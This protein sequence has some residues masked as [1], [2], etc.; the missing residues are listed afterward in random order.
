M[1]PYPTQAELKQILHY[2]PNTGVFTWRVKTTQ[3]TKVGAVAGC[4]D[5]HNNCS[6]IRIDNKAFLAHRLAWIYIYGDTDKGIR[7]ING[8][9]YDN[10]IDNLALRFKETTAKSKGR[11]MSAIDKLIDKIVAR[12]QGNDNVNVTPLFLIKNHNVTRATAGVIC[13]KLQELKP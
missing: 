9:G 4:F 12:Y 1:K 7:H 2:D 8:I 10:R 6:V 3:T 13:S 5:A 11:K